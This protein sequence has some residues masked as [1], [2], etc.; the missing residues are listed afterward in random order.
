M[1]IKANPPAVKDQLLELADLLE[2]DAEIP[3]RLAA[4]CAAYLRDGLA[5]DGKL[6]LGNS[7]GRPKKTWERLSRAIRVAGL[8][9]DGTRIPDA[10]EAV[11]ADADVSKWTVDKDYKE[12]RKSAK[13]IAR[14]NSEFPNWLAHYEELKAMLKTFRHDDGR[15]FDDDDVA[16][17]VRDLPA[18]KLHFYVYRIHYYGTVRRD[19]ALL[20][21]VLS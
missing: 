5:N 13:Q 17:I 4:E 3:P 15:Y 18:S 8:K 19:K 12:F 20:D 7:T 11:A 2:N 1:T 9:L 10:C 6:P 14:V 16:A 21:K